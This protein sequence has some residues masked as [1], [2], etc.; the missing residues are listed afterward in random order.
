MKKYIS[1]YIPVF[2]ILFAVCAFG[3]S[4]SD[5]TNESAMPES[6]AIK[7]SISEFEINFAKSL[8]A[9][10][11]SA[12]QTPITVIGYKTIEIPEEEQEEFKYIFNKHKTKIEQEKGLYYSED[13]TYIRLYC[14]LHTA[15]IEIE[16][17]K[18]VLTDKGL[19]LP[20]EKLSL[21]DIKIYGRR[22]TDK[23][24]G[25]GC[26]ILKNDTIIIGK[27]LHQTGTYIDD[28]ICVFD[29]GKKG[30]GSCCDSGV[31]ASTRAEN[32]SC[33]ENHG[34]VN[35]TIAFGYDEGRCWFESKKCMDYNGWATDCVDGKTTNFPG[36]DCYYA[37]LA[38]HCWNELM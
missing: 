9:S 12:G 8:S 5:N 33:V 35:C 16:G 34:G 24:R 36:S 32:V 11:R 15:F 37:M 31:E 38:G 19:I 2:F 4:C 3:C 26:N 6:K 18:H 10:V 27:D 7:K 13:G 22:R 30:L 29:L 14:P 21:S 17:K 23:V 28:N 20:D 1:S 25:T